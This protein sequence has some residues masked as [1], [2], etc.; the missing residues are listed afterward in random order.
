[1]N[2]KN[3]GKKEM[4]FN[5]VYSEKPVCTLKGKWN[6]TLTGESGDVKQVIEGQNVICTNGKEFLASFLQSAAG[7][8]S[9][10][11]MKYIA[12]GSDSSAEA[13]GNTALGGE[14]ARTTGTVS[15]VSGAIYQVT[16][17]FATGSG[18]GSI[19]EYG[20]LSSSSA[21]TM[22]SRDTEAVINK[23]ANDTLTVVCQLTLT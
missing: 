12:I 18:T 16:A 23:G 15:Y 22:L 13:A 6:M 20:L 4:K 9:T 17:T 10:F 1:M 3:E 14:L 5:A 21:G 8:A 7:A 19:Y 11:T 2:R